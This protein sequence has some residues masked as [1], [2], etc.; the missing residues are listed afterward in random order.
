MYCKGN[1]EVNWTE[2]KDNYNDYV[3]ASELDKKSEEVQAATLKT[4]MGPQWKKILTGLKLSDDKLKDPKEIT[5]ALE[6]VFVV[7]HNVLYD[8]SL[9]YSA[10]Q[11]QHDTVDQF[12][13]RLRHLATNSK[14]KEE[15]EMIRDILVLGC[16]DSDARARLFRREECSLKTAIEMLKIDEITKQQLKTLHGGHDQQQVH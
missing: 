12:V 6:A 3:I 1:M 5:A 2:F 11:Q 4:L 15:E 9:F 8:R 13:D 14:F 10:V 7:K 16:K